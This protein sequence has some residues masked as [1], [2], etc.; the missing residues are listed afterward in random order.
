[1]FVISGSKHTLDT[2]ALK[3]EGTHLLFNTV[4][5]PD[6]LM[7]DSLGGHEHT[8]VELFK[9]MRITEISN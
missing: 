6:E 5:Q 8:A 4:S 7:T 1:M 9:I 2:C 3:E